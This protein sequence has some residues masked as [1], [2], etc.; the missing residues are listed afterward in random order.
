MDAYF[1]QMVT[2]KADTKTYISMAAVILAAV[3]IM[4]VSILFFRY[5]GFFILILW[6]LVI[7]GAYYVISGMNVEFEYVVTNE[8]LEID[9]IVAQRRR[10]KMVTASCQTFEALGSQV[11]EPYQ[12]GRI[13]VVIHAAPSEMAPENY[14]A[15]FVKDNTRYMIVFAPND[16]ILAHIRRH[17]RRKAL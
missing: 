13:D 7:F 2:K 1:E 12:G 15:V 6:A 9:K 11:N 5:T 14:Y 16:E 4:V 10:K 3:L 8:E 17:V